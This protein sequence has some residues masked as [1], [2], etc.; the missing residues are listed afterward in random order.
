MD[1]EK[2]TIDG[3][4]VKNTIHIGNKEI[5]FAENLTK[6][7]SYMVCS[8]QWDN[9]L[10]I[11]VY[12]EAAIC[13]DY[14]EA[15]AEFLYRASSQVQHVRDQRAERGVTN[16]SLTI[17]GCAPGSK[18]AHYMNQLVVIRPEA[19]IASSRTVD[20]QLLLA[21]QLPA[22]TGRSG[23]CTKSCLNKTDVIAEYIARL[24]PF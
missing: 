4:E 3:Y 9:H 21:N 14:L 6:S 18:N 22:R 24:K 13:T 20:E 15:M 5:L 2:R 17:A 19:M 16:E 1:E 7:E 23:H 12:A 11:D 10:G 8:C